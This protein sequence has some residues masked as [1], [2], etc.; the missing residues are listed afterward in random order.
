[1]ADIRY[2]HVVVG[3]VEQAGVGKNV[4][5]RECDALYHANGMKD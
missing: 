3:V 5:M 2:D 4:N 1:M